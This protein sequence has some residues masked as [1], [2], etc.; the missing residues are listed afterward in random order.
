VRR[1]VYPTFFQA[2][3]SDFVIAIIQHLNSHFRAV[4]ASLDDPHLP[5]RVQAALALTEMVQLHASGISIYFFLEDS[6]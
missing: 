3:D 1:S 6:S 4:A 5:V 2:C